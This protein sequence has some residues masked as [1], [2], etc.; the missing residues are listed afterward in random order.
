MISVI[1]AFLD[2]LSL[3]ILFGCFYTV[4]KSKS[5]PVSQPTVT[6]GELE[7]KI[8]KGRRNRR[9]W[10]RTEFTAKSQDKTRGF[11]GE[12][13]ALKPT[14]LGE[15][16]NEREK[17]DKENK[18]KSSIASSFCAGVLARNSRD[19]GTVA[20]CIQHYKSALEKCGFR[21]GRNG[22]IRDKQGWKV[23]CWPST[24]YEVC[25]RLDDDMKVDLVEEHALK[26]LCVNFLD[27]NK[28][29]N[30]NNLLINSDFRINM[31]TKDP[32]KETSDLYRKLVPD[33][34]RPILE[35]KQGLNMIFLMA[36]FFCI[37]LICHSLTSSSLLL[38]P[39]L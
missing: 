8:E 31:V 27:G 6:V 24:S 14:L 33:H 29:E 25:L 18:K 20:S 38:F 16:F 15:D 13:I 2:S 9:Q 4:D 39:L 36:F 23:H 37:D 7:L 35:L 34:T 21:E 17:K 19:D 3:S 30:S 22:Y 12:K 32:V 5:I 26:W 1:F 28:Q 10:E 11:F